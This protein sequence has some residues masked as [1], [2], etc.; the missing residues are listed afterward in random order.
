MI[1][2]SKKNRTRVGHMILNTLYSL[3]TRFQTFVWAALVIAHKDITFW[4]KFVPILITFALCS[5]FVKFGNAGYL[6]KEFS[7]HPAQIANKWWTSFKARSLLMVVVTVFVLFI[8][9][10]EWK[11]RLLIL[12]WLL[13]AYIYQSFD[14]I[15]QYHRAYVKAV[16]IEAVGIVVILIFVYQF[17]LT[18]F[19]LVL[20][21][22]SMMLMKVVL[23]SIV[24]YRQ[25]KIPFDLTI[26]LQPLRMMFP[27][28]M[29]GIVGLLN[30]RIDVYVVS[31]FETDTQ[32]GRYQI[33]INLVMIFMSGVHFI[34]SP[35][36]KNLYRINR[37]SLN[38]VIQKMSFLGVTLAIVWLCFDWAILTYV[39]QQVYHIKFYLLGFLLIVPIYMYYPL[40]IRLFKSELSRQVTY[41]NAT[42]VLINLVLNVILIPYF[43]LI[44]AL[45]GTVVSQWFLFF[46]YLY[47]DKT[48]IQ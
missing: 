29:I 30:S 32:V 40:S 35:Y 34:A 10:W 38:L 27:F 1:S 33:F 11:I 14:V 15:I 36:T 7:L 18:L 21:G 4:G 46:S 2:I 5:H 47:L 48:R 9:V 8:P 41:M 20:T 22:V 37:K 31:Y 6:L 44:G 12:I 19:N 23:Y 39:F 13:L 25:V 45:I 43:H 16:L 28:F 24:L 42:S 17:Q 26:D 3:I